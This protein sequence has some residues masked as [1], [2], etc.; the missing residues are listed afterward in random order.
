MRDD[1]RTGGG[2]AILIRDPVTGTFTRTAATASN[3]FRVDWL[4]SYHPTPGTVGYLGY[5]S[6]LIEPTAFRFRDLTRVSDG[7]FVKL[8][9]LFRV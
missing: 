7:F 6:S 2:G 5:G 1:S 3:A 4:F 8:S 9:Y